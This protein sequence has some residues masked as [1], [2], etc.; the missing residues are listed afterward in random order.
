MVSMVPAWLRM[1]ANYLMFSKGVALCQRFFHHTRPPA[2]ASGA[3]ESYIMSAHL[4][5]VIT[6]EFETL[7]ACYTRP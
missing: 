3:C 6:Y 7:H 4:L 2:R 5:Q 1:T